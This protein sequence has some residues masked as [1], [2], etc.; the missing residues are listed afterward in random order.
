MQ[1]KEI[2]VITGKHRFFGQSRKPWVSINTDKLLGYFEEN[3]YKVQIMDFHEAINQN[4]EIKD[5]IIIYA[6]SQKDNYRNYIQDIV[7]HLSKQNTVIPA[8]DLLKCHENKGYQELYLK[9]LGIQSLKTGYFSSASEVNTDDYPFPF[10]LKTIKGSN[11]KGVF[12]I[13]NEHAFHK[14]TDSLM[15]NFGTVTTLDLFRRKYLRKKKFKYYPEHSDRKDYYGYKD[16]ITREE[17]F[18]IQQ[19]IAGLSFDYRVLAA[20]DRFYVMK[21][22][23][24]PGDFRASGSKIF[25]FN[26]QPETGLL[27]FASSIYNKFDSPFLSMDI[28]FDGKDYY[29]AEYQASHFGVTTIVGSRGYF[30]N[31]QN[32]SWEYVEEKPQLEYVY[33]KTYMN[34]ISNL[35]PE[36]S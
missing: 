25:N 29:L 5:K 23:V 12:L 30:S 13:K 17:N 21:R 1:Q 28:L 15:K 32:Q 2:L 33:A 36:N 4:H 26:E 10:I 11:G 22:S 24:M 9:S 35:K 3:D 8:Y 34:Y 31:P 7:F 18:V 19:Y 14:I 6:F 20:F 16:Y 27:D